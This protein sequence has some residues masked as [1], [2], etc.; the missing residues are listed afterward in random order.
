MRNQ[1]TASSRHLS[2]REFLQ[3]PA[4]IGA[5]PPNSTFARENQNHSLPSSFDALKPFGARVKSIT[6]DEY[7]ARVARAQQLLAEQKLQ[8]DALFVAPG[9]SLF[10]FT[11]VRWWPSERL[12]GFLI[13]QKGTPVVI[14]PAFEE[15][16]FR[17]QLRIPAEVRVWQEDESPTKLAASALANRGLRTGRVAV[18]E[19]T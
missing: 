10:Y 14:C 7:Q 17:E 15:A 13:P 11:G 5:C 2:R 8:I 16:R 12:L 19:A 3:P 6:S 4:V 1:L 18:E 9:T